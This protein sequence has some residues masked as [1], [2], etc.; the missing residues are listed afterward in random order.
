MLII[1]K[2]KNSLISWEIALFMLK[3]S[4]REKATSNK[5]PALRKNKSMT[6]VSTSSQLF[7]RGSSTEAIFSKK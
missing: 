2:L 6:V 7:I 5:F 3:D 1:L 4:H